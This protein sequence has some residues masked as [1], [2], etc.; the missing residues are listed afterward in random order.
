MTKRTSKRTTGDGSAVF[1][2]GRKTVTIQFKSLRDFENK[3]CR[4]VDRY[5]R[6]ACPEIVS[7]AY[8]DAASMGRTEL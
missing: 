3:M 5:L 6:E 4:V 7:F 8:T 1:R 2:V